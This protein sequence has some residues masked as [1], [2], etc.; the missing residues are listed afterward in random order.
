MIIPS[1]VKSIGDNAFGNFSGTYAE[2]IKS[3]EIPETVTMVS[4]DIFG[5]WT[6][7]QTVYLPFAKGEEPAGWDSNWAGGNSKA[8]FVY[9][10]D[11]AD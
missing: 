1:S 6:A 5:S 11:Q 8:T 3:I 2:G 4:Y 9:K 7:D 10:N